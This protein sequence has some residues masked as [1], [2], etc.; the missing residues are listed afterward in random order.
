MYVTAAAASTHARPGPGVQPHQQH[1]RG[2]SVGAQAASLLRASPPSSVGATAEEGVE[3]SQQATAE[4]P[5]LLIAQ[6]EEEGQGPSV[7]VAEQGA[8]VEKEAL[9]VPIQDLLREAHAGFAPIAEEVEA[10]DEAEASQSPVV[11]ARPERLQPLQEEEML[12]LPASPGEQL[13]RKS[14]LA[15]GVSHGAAPAAAGED[16]VVGTPASEGAESDPSPTKA[17]QRK[18]FISRV[19][20]AFGFGGS[21]KV[22][23]VVGLGGIGTLNGVS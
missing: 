7:A 18:G 23:R 22:R 20:K 4:S 11:P 17:K 13:H 5:S 1:H 6:Q 16:L 19:R 12:H 10:E 15:I 9:V 8:V 3:D 2:S 21:G 14:V